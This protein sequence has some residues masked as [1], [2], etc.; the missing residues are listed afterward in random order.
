M[1]SFLRKCQFW[2]NFLELWRA[3]FNI[4]RKPKKA[5]MKMALKRSGSGSKSQE[6]EMLYN[7]RMSKTPLGSGIK[8]EFIV[9]LQMYLQTDGWAKADVSQLYSFA[10]A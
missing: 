3:M 9:M 5:V 6:I 2:S 4:L 7:V 1:R 8:F 10:L